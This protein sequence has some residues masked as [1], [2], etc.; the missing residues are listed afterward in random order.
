MHVIYAMSLMTDWLSIVNNSKF[1]GLSECLAEMVKSLQRTL[2]LFSHDM[3]GLYLYAVNWI[4][5]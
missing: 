2:F 5:H 4:S 1:L 3:L